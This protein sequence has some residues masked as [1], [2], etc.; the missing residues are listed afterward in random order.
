MAFFSKRSFVWI[1]VLSFFVI[2]LMPG[3]VQSPSIRNTILGVFGSISLLFQFISLGSVNSEKSKKS[4]F[5]QGIILIVLTIAL[6]AANFL[7]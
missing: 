4:D 2:I 6:L 5:T 7:V 3:M 1:I